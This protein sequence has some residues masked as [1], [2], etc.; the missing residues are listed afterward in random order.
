MVFMNEKA[1]TL[2]S[3]EKAITG[4]LL[5]K[6]RSTPYRLMRR[7]ASVAFSG[8]ALLVFM[9][10]IITFGLLIKLESRGPIFYRGKRVGKG[11]KIFTMFKLRTLKQDAENQIGVHLLQPDSQHFTRIGRFVRRTKL[12]EVPQFYNVIRGEMNIVGPRPVRPIRAHLFLKTN[13]RFQQILQVRPGIT[14]LSQVLAGYYDPV[15]KK[16]QYD[17]EYINRR[18]LSFDLKV[19]IATVWKMTQMEHRL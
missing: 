15:D 13:P 18:R 14:G 6:N 1:L 3:P 9:P 5:D 16:F 17:L 2:A 4:G 12:D 7:A 8:A 19:V 11:G 10:L